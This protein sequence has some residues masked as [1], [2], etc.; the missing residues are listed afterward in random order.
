MAHRKEDH[1][2]HRAHCTHF[3]RYYLRSKSFKAFLQV[4]TG[5]FGDCYVSAPFHRQKSFC[6]FFL[7]VITM[8]QINSTNTTEKYCISFHSWCSDSVEK[9][10]I[11]SEWKKNKMKKHTE[12]H[13]GQRNVNTQC[14]LKIVQLNSS[15]R[16]YSHENPFVTF[17]LYF[18]RR[19]TA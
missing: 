3:T 5:A 12:R 8:V 13:H 17:S 18:Y 19:R 11:H 16:C 4:T 9:C 2:T 14:T 6:F 7:D 10:H 15:L 1:I